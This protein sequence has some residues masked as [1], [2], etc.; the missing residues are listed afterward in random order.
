MDGRQAASGDDLIG[1]VQQINGGDLK[2]AMDG[3]NA[4][5]RRDPQSAPALQLMALVATK[6]G[7]QG[8]ALS[9]AERAHAIEPDFREYPAML[10]YLCATVGRLTDAL[11]YAKLSTVLAPHPQGDMLLPANLPMN[12]AIF[13]HIGMS[14]HWML[15]EAA[16]HAG[17]AEEAAREAEAELRINPGKYETLVLLARARQALGQHDVALAHLRAAAASRPDAALVHRFIGDVLLSLGEH[18]QAL[19]SFRLA[20][21]LES[22]PEE[23]AVTHAL[24]C[25]PLQTEA[26]H[27]AAAPFAAELAARAQG[28]RRAAAIERQTPLIG[29]LW[30]QCHAGPLADFVLPVLEHMD[31]VVLYRLNR[32]TD[33]VTEIARSKVM[34]F[35]DCPD[36]DPATFDRIVAGDMPGAII[37]LCTSIEEPRFPRLAGS[38]AAPVVQWLGRPMPDRLPGADRIV[39]SP[40]TMAVDRASFGDEAVVKLPRLLA[41]KFPSTGDESESIR[42][43]PRQAG[44]HVTFGAVADFRRITPDTVAL[45]AAVL[46]A[47]PG[48]RLAIGGVVQ[49]WP[50]QSV[51]KLGGLFANFGLAERVNLQG[52]PD[53]GAAYFDFLGRVDVLLDSWPVAGLGE[54]AEALWLGVPVVTLA[55][56]RRAGLTGAAVLEAAGQTGWTAATAA[57]Y[58][59]IAAALADSADLPALRTGLRDQLAASPLCDVEGFA[60][61][62]QSA[63]LAAS[64]RSADAA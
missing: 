46:R 15:A 49:P 39:G 37:N 17:Q 51:E 1:I 58:V 54:V 11:Y 34:R 33:A 44:G 14:M 26:N 32:R 6:M 3:C 2:A 20:V 27:R 60:K 62:L 36:L 12:R 55:G 30:D 40:A 23:L 64:M 19:A 57:D 9:L 8:L 56:S 63:L 10:A 59:S 38:P 4:L 41:W 47:V 31:P 53:A 29:I 13:D 43:S 52:P 24:A 18:D 35:Q 7:D 48:A 22:D 50:K 25:L 28:T 42:P 21:A 61:Q 16:L 45:W 5:M